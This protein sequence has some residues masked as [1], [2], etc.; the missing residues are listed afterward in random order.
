MPWPTETP[1]RGWLKCNGSAFDKA[2]YSQLAV[3]YPSGFLPDLR[4]EFI[5]GLDD[6]RG[7][8]SGRG[9]LSNQDSENKQHNHGVE[10]EN[11]LHYS[12]NTGSSSFW[13]SRVGFFNKVSGISGGNESRPRNIAFN[14]IVR[15]A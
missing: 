6:G 2:L 3:A 7:I 9:L 11:I 12:G 5:R 1:P 15:A 8:D 4:G 10:S 13:L 14:Y